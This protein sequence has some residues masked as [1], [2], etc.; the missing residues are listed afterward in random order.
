M[1]VP[2][3][4]RPIVEYSKDAKSFT[5]KVPLHLALRR[6]CFIAL[7]KGNGIPTAKRESRAAML[8]QTRVRHMQIAKV[9]KLATELL[10]VSLKKAF[11]DAYATGNFAQPYFPM[12][13]D[14]NV[15]KIY[16]QICMNGA[17]VHKF[18]NNEKEPVPFVKK[19]AT[20]EIVERFMERDNI[21]T[22]QI[23]IPGVSS[24]FNMIAVQ[25]K[26]NI[27]EQLCRYPQFLDD[28]LK[29]IASLVQEHSYSPTLRSVD[30]GVHLVNLCS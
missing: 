23:E 18:R 2:R 30:L 6:E 8:A 15:G 22:S 7:A 21:T 17:L 3:D 11:F 14:E 16:H 10:D 19:Y 26:T 28:T 12:D 29:H 9:R 4:E 27:K 5:L 20:P 25:V 1:H 24:I 13:I